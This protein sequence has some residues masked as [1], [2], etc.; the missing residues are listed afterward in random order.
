MPTPSVRRIIQVTAALSILGAVVGG[1]LGVLGFALA[2]TRLRFSNRA[3]RS[4]VE[5]AGRLNSCS[6]LLDDRMIS[7]ISWAGLL[8]LFPFLLG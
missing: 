2:A 5:R 8:G 7:T 6:F 1:M 4:Q 3:R